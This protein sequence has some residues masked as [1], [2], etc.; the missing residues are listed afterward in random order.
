MQSAEARLGWLLIGLVIGLTGGSATAVAQSPGG[1]PWVWS[2]EGEPGRQAPAGV[3]YF[4]KSFVGKPHGSAGPLVVEG[5]LDIAADDAFRVWINGVEIGRGADPKR[6]FRFDVARHIVMGTNVLA[7]EARNAGGP[8]GLLVRL[9]YV[10]S[11]SPR[12]LIRG[13]SSWKWST[14]GPEGW[15]RPDFD[16][17]SWASARELGPYGTVGPWKR[18]TWD[19]GG[20]DRFSAPPG[21]RVDSAA[22]NPDPKDPFSLINLTFDDRGRLLVSQEGGPVLLCT[23]PDA[24]GT[25]QSVTPYCEQVKGSQGMCWVGDALYLIGNGPDGAGLYRVRDT[26]GDDRTDSVETL[27]RFPTV[28][29]PGYGR[30]GGIGEHGPHAVLHGPD[31]QIYL[32]VGNH[33]WARPDRLAANSPLT[34]WP[35]GQ[36]GPDQG[37]PGTTED[38]LLPRINESH[39]ANILAPGGTI[40]RL[41]RAGKSTALVAAGFRN[42]YDADFG[43]DGELF[44]FDSD[45]DGDFGLPWYRPVRVCHVVPGADFVWRTSS[46]NTPSYYIDS[47]PPIL[48]TGAGSPT[49]VASY[50]SDAFP[51]RYRGALF[52][53]DWTLGLIYA[54]FPER[55]G[56]TYRARAERFCA[57]VPMNVTDVAVGPDGALYFSLGGRLSRGGVFRIVH[58]QSAQ[59]TK[60]D[61]SAAPIDRLL[62]Q[63]QHLAPWRRREAREILR[64]SPSLS[65]ELARIAAGQA[66]RTATERIRA[67]DLLVEHGPAPDPVLLRALAKEEDPALRAHAIRTIGIE[68]YR[69][70][71]ETLS[72]GLGD[73]DP[74][75]RRRACEALIR[76]GIDPALDRLWPVLGDSDRFVRTSARLVLAR[77]DAAA[78]IGRLSSEPN[79]QV[80]LEATVALAQSDRADAYA[81]VIFNRLA[82][83]EPGSDPARWLELLRVH[84]LVLIH[85]RSR[86]QSASALAARV[87]AAF[88]HP[89]PRVSRE[90][91]I[92]LTGLK[93]SG[94]RASAIH[95]RLLE[96]LLASPHDR[97][98][99]IFYFYCLRLLRDGWT[100]A[101]KEALLAWFD[102]MRSWSGGAYYRFFQEEILRQLAPIFTTDDLGRL[103]ARG[104][105]LPWAATVLLRVTA[106][107]QWPGPVALGDLDRRVS[108]A[109]EMPAA[110]E[111]KGAILAALSRTPGPESQSVL[112]AIADRDHSRTG[113]VA[114]ALAARPSPADWPYLVRGL[115]VSNPLVLFDVMSALRTLPDRPK[116]N[117]PAPCRAV[118]IASRKLDAAGRRRAV[119]VLRHWVAKRFIAE[120]ADAQTELAAWATWYAQTFPSA[121]PLPG[122]TAR[123]S[124]SKYTV[125]SI[126]TFLES[127]LEKPRDDPQQGRALFV[128]A[129]CVKCHRFGKEGEGIGPD[130]TDVARKFDRQYILES[131][132]SPSKVISD[133][134]RSTTVATV[135]GQVLNGLAIPQ[136]GRI[137]LLL[138]DGTK[139]ALEKEEVESQSSSL[140]SVMP[141]GLLDGL[142][143]A[144]IAQLLRY[145]ESGSVART[146]SK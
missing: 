145:L 90:L 133:Q 54:V 7:V 36:M 78:W 91:A 74:V 40:W 131:I 16:D 51:A 61:Q 42:Q 132:L 127:S 126:R 97:Q 11:N 105:R 117:D 138:S 82:R 77:I 119:A 146:E 120:D 48:E 22:R 32:V 35:D 13:D 2:D 88:P 118:L 139:A 85:T 113:D 89:D 18:L 87:E 137:V 70:S 103:V 94:E 102:G 67:I 19:A 72:A 101:Q 6:V 80:A 69:G 136:G 46:A 1:V 29:V 122:E 47:L 30:N 114:R 59:K 14:G 23:Q 8:A 62:T 63:T 17:S 71:A 28:D 45:M 134:Y 130:L 81:T 27:H 31:G 106:P 9:G 15:L 98:Q 84:Q 129:Q 56:A 20:D 26:N 44:T 111:L 96:A 49:G 38:V 140:V 109:S 24:D 108:E 135:N 100:P 43:R 92:V 104:E 33:A 83:V 107:A 65:A 50:E 123:Q 12:L 52:M 5:D 73:R 57:G 76:A 58:E 128:K 144:E 60:T 142:S 21:F 86:P 4:R 99:Q 93:R 110:L 68:G 66:G 25:F 124:T 95:A 55:D 75:V 53:A 10:P 79:D 3:R 141:E 115:E 39:A 41:D 34:R 125:E 143:K 37:K 116:P 112:R 121:P 64:D